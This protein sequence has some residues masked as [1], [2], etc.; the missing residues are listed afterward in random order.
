[1]TKPFYRALFALL[2]IATVAYRFLTPQPA[3]FDIHA[4]AS[5]VLLHAGA[6]RREG[7]VLPDTGLLKPMYFAAPGCEGLLQVIPVR[8]N[9]EE[10]PAFDSVV[11]RGYVRRF[12][13]L[14]KTWSAESR[15]DMRLEWLKAKALSVLGLSPYVSATTGLLIASP[16]GC[17][18]ADRIDWSQV[19]LRHR[20]TASP[21]GVPTP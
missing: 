1:M 5:D 6:T 8:L 18:V 17:T 4:A 16:P 2:L 19:W 3:W 7:P 15:L 9:L 20:S 12:A 14:G 13:Y 21:S 11:E 10:S